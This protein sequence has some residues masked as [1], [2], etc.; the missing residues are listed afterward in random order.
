[1]AFGRTKLLLSFALLG[2]LVGSATYLVFN[3]IITNSAIGIVYV[4]P[5]PILE[6]IS[7]PWF[8]SGIAGS[9][10][11]VIVIYVSAHFS[12]EK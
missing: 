3:W 2:F 6:V 4:Y 7:A 10:L 9:L 12:G 11:S 1:M 5:T 8:L